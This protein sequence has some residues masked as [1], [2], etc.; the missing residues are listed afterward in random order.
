MRRPHPLQRRQ[1]GLSLL[2]LLLATTLGLLLGAAALQLLLEVRRNQ[3][4]L[5]RSAL[6][7][8]S[9]R[10]ALHSLASSSRQA[11]FWASFLPEHDN[12]YARQPLT[13]Y[14]Q[15]L[16]PPTPCL[17]F[18]QWSA[19]EQDNR[20]RMP[21]QSFAAVPAGC[22]SLLRQHKA[23]SDILLVRH[24]EAQPSSGVGNARLH[25]QVALCHRQPRGH[26]RLAAS[27]FDALQRDCQTPAPLH[28]YLERLYF[29]RQDH[30]LMRAERIGNEGSE[31]NLQP[32]VDGIEQLVVEL[33]LDQRD[34][35]GSPVDYQ[36]APQPLAGRSQARYRGDGRAEGPFVRCPLQGC[37]AD[38]L[39]A[40]VVVRLHVLARAAQR[41][42]LPGSQ[43][44]YQMG[45]SSYPV[46]ERTGARLRELH[47]LSVLLPH[48]ALRRQ[49]P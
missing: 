19:D 33:G 42:S 24:V 1:H 34:A 3:A 48:V 20:L 15:R 38:Q 40:V 39:L 9:A 11:G 23:G 44:R 10:F 47:S 16:Q 21:L 45:G 35:E 7:S 37:T 46:D 25:L 4:A 31:W 5:E 29:V 27:G 14:P 6:V 18:A 32:L 22:E 8:E 13:G 30:T 41:E 17:P 28:R 36:R 2:E 43:R 49:A 26:Y 12:P